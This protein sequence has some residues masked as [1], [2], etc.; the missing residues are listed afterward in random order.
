MP[1][2]VHAL[3]PARH[4]HHV[5]MHQNLGEG[6]RSAE[7]ICMCFHRWRR[8]TGPTGRS[9]GSG[10]AALRSSESDQRRSQPCLQDTENMAGR[11]QPFCHL[12]APSGVASRVPH[13]RERGCCRMVVTVRGSWGIPVK[14][15]TKWPDDTCITCSPGSAAQQARSAGVSVEKRTDLASNSVRLDSH[16]KVR[17]PLPSTIS[18]PTSLSRHGTCG[19]QR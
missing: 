12:A 10:A 9:G 11:V 2:A 1:S 7:G 18:L 8:Q 4:G 13:K 5:W 14:F 16:V 17:R 15:S 6:G 3:L 19:G